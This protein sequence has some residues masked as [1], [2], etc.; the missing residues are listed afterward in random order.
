[1]PHDRSRTLVYTD[2][3]VARSH[4]HSTTSCFRLAL[5]CSTKPAGDNEVLLPDDDDVEKRIFEKECE[6]TDTFVQ[7]SGMLLD[8][9]QI[10]CDCQKMRWLHIYDRSAALV[11]GLVLNRMQNANSL[12]CL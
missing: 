3:S 2:K 4:C 8:V 5:D 1:M 12:L 10:L 6:A 9:V 7:I 11:M